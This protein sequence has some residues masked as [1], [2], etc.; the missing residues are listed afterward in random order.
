MFYGN[1]IIMHVVLINTNH[2]KR[3]LIDRSEATSL[4]EDR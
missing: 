2:I 4:Y 3:S 1:K